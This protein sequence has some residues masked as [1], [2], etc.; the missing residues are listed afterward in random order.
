MAANGFIAVQGAV[1]ALDHLTGRSTALEAEWLA[2]SQ[3]GDPLP[4]A[5]YLML[6]TQV[7][8]DAQTDMT[9][10][11][12]IEASGTGYARQPI[13]WL[14]A[15]VGTRTATTSDLVQFG[16][17][18]DPTGLAAPVTGAAL[19]TRM[20]SSAGQPAGLC[21]MAWNLATPITTSQNQA[22]QLAAGSLQMTLA[23]G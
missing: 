17:F 8:T 22:L 10:L 7:V 2:K 11:T 14:A 20:T 19:V 15:A 23:V 4:R 5:T 13:P 9:T 18:P 1:S 16:P 3:A 6:L 21:V 12:G